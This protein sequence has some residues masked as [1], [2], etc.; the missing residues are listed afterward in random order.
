MGGSGFYPL[1]SVREEANGKNLVEVLRQPAGY[2]HAA[3]ARSGRMRQE[4][5]HGATQ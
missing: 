1:A 4:E 3:I 2:G 5:I